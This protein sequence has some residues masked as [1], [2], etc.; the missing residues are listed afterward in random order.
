MVRGGKKRHV[1][2]DARCDGPCFSLTSSLRGGFVVNSVVCQVTSANCEC[3][4][5]RIVDKDASVCM[6]A[7]I[8]HTSYLTLQVLSNPS[9]VRRSNFPLEASSPLKSVKYLT[10]RRLPPKNILL[11]VLNY[12]IMLYGI[13]M[14]S[15]EKTAI[16]NCCHPSPT[17]SHLL[18]LSHYY[19]MI[20]TID[21]IC[22][23]AAAL[24][25]FNRTIGTRSSCASWPVGIKSKRWTQS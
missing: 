18:T 1:G 20:Y 4:L 8:T 2:R 12:Y 10:T 21:D 16:R 22:S 9:L 13:I 3:G 15:G 19:T 14:R 25:A 24:V 5:R 7:I 6:Q 11:T 17:T 23:Q